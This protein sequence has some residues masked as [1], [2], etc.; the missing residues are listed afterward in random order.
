MARCVQDKGAMCG[1]SQRAGLDNSMDMDVHGMDG[2]QAQGPNK[3]AL[4][5]HACGLESCVHLICRYA[6]G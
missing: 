1:S 3:D 5:H 6:S 4:V 2:V